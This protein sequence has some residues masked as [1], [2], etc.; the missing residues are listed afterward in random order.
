MMWV[1]SWKGDVG[2]G[3]CAAMP[4]VAKFALVGVIAS[5]AEGFGGWGCGGGC[6]CDC[7]CD[8]GCG[9]ASFDSGTGGDVDDMSSGL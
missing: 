6:G 2:N 7:D 5:S 8:C 3:R 1:I 9:G 4:L